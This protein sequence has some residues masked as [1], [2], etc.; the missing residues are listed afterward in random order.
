[1]GPTT[2]IQTGVEA[3]VTTEMPVDR[4]VG[5]D[6]LRQSTFFSNRRKESPIMAQNPIVPSPS[7]QRNG[8]ADSSLH[9]QMEGGDQVEPR[10]GESTAAE[11]T[12]LYSREA[13]R[14]NQDYPSTLGLVKHI[15]TV[16]VDKPPSQSWFRVHDDPNYCCDM[17]LL[18]VKAG[19]DR[20]IYQVGANLLS[21]LCEE[22]LLKPMRLVLC[23]DRQ[24]EL[25][26]WPLRLPGLDGREDDWMTSALAVAEQAK[27]RWV[28]LLA[29]ANSYHSRTT[30]AVI[31]NPDWPKQ[32]YDQ[33][34]ELAFAKRRIA[35]NSHPVLRRL[36]EGV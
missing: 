28:Q 5:S 16:P 2:E 25:R 33:L 23:I 17:Y 11:P 22:R 35:A 15:H 27:H 3:E 21:L 29:G 6:P 20:G 30:Q 36:R 18:Q 7:A 10:S 4:T 13:L 12:N 1:M 34:L 31:P 14:V 19:P 32:T 9:Q 24:E 8:D 26:L